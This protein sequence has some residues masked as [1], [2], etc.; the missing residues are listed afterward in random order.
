MW[1]SISEARAV[2]LI[3]GF[4]D[5]SQARKMAAVAL[6]T[7]SV[8]LSSV[9]RLMQLAESILWSNL[10]KTDEVDETCEMWTPTE[11]VGCDV[12]DICVVVSYI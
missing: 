1:K 9:C 7:E 6:A 2:R 4:I 10:L 8:F 3:A 11:C 5:F 12:P